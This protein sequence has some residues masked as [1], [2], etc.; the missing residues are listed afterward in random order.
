MVFFPPLSLSATPAFF[1]RASQSLQILYPVLET[2]KNFSPFSAFGNIVQILLQF[3]LL[4]FTL[5]YLG[6]GNWMN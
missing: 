2:S 1:V 3:K 6:Y 5:F 4:S